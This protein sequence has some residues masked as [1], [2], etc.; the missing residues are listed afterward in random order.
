MTLPKNVSELFKIVDDLNSQG[1]DFLYFEYAYKLYVDNG[2]DV[3]FLT[4]LKDFSL[5]I[6]EA[7]FSDIAK[8]LNYSDCKWINNPNF[9][10]TATYNKEYFTIERSL[11]YGSGFFNDLSNN[12]IYSLSCSFNENGF[13]IEHK[14]FP[15]NRKN[16]TFFMTSQITTND[17]IFVK[18]FHVINL[19]NLLYCHEISDQDWLSILKDEGNL[20]TFFASSLSSMSIEDN[21]FNYYGCLFNP[22]NQDKLKNAIPEDFV[23]NPRFFTKLSGFIYSYFFMAQLESEGIMNIRSRMFQNHNESRYALQFSTVIHYYDKDIDLNFTDNKISVRLIRDSINSLHELPEINLLLETEHGDEEPFKKIQDAVKIIASDVENFYNQ[24]DNE[25]EYYN[26]IINF[27]ASHTGSDFNEQKK[28]IDMQ[29]IKNESWCNPPDIK[30]STGN[31]SFS[32]N[33]ENYESEILSR[34]RQFESALNR[35][36]LRNKIKEKDKIKNTTRI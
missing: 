19:F 21:D 25:K 13:Y 9:E 6:A 3:N 8:E 30:I 7:D 11:S 27:I 1:N 23:I 17:K 18:D 32:F 14:D 10:L 28:F 36:L 5:D 16:L 24:W 15:Y 20:R 29:I 31:Y 33:Y 22:I 12:L 4:F 35:N 26:G 2:K 34:I